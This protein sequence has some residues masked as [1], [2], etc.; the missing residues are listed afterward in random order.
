[1]AGFDELRK[2]VEANENVMTVRMD[3][4]RNEAGQRRLGRHVASDI[5]NQLRRRGLH[6]TPTEL[7]VDATREVR[8]YV[9]GTPVAEVIEAVLEPGEEG[10][11][12]LRALAGGESGEILQRIR[13]LVCE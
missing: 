1:M 3:E 9:L 5:S 10:D 12:K 7:P 2:D 4:L 11:Q 8:L 6:H 13:A